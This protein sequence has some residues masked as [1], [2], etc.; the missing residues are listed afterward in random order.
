M[1]ALERLVRLGETVRTL[2]DKAFS[3]SGGFNGE[4]HRWN[5][6]FPHS[7]GNLSARRFGRDAG[8]AHAGDGR[9]NVPHRD[10]RR[11][12]S[13]CCSC[14]APSAITASGMDCARTWPTAIASWPTPSA[15][16]GRPNGRVTSPIR[17]MCTPPISSRCCRRSASA[18]HLVGLSNGGPI[19]LRAPAEAPDLV[20][21]VVVYEPTVDDVL[22]GDPAGEEAVNEFFGGFGD[23]AAASRQRTPTAR[24]AQPE[25]EAEVGGRGDRRR[26]GHAD[27][28]RGQVGVE[29]DGA[30]QEQQHQPG[31]R[32]QQDREADQDRE[33]ARPQR[34]A[35]LGAGDR[36]APSP[37]RGPAR[38]GA[39]STGRSRCDGSGRTEAGGDAEDQQPVGLAPDPG[40]RL[41]SWRGTRRPL[42]IH[43]SRPSSA[44]W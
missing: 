30:G 3:S 10:R 9:S 43:P 2:P 42:R 34:L 33:P 16:S 8:A 25:D 38:R 29:A 37:A 5:F 15:G 7:V 41:R 14:T 6:G 24:Q 22:Y 20:R 19:V 40:E 11:A 1:R 12:A 13:L 39:G 36:P 44:R 27:Q 31:D 21:S 35:E 28:R 17:R 18:V 23:V 32:H 4:V 26:G